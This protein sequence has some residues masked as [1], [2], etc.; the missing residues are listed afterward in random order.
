MKSGAFSSS[1]GRISTRSCSARTSGAAGRQPRPPRC[2]VS[3]DAVA[4]VRRGVIIIENSGK[5]LTQRHITC[6]LFQEN[7]SENLRSNIQIAKQRLMP[8]F[9][10]CRKMRLEIST[11][12]DAHFPLP[13]LSAI[14]SSLISA[15]INIARLPRSI[16]TGKKCM[17]YMF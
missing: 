1:C 15:E 7:R 13:I 2:A 3:G 12:C 8:G 5:R 9:I 4:G 16:S 17:F 14:K 10:S 11:N 6:I